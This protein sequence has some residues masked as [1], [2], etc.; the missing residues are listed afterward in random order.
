MPSPQKH[1]P[2]L[3]VEASL[4]KGEQVETMPS[5]ILAVQLQGSCQAAQYCTAAIW[6]Q[7]AIICQQSGLDCH[8][9]VG[10]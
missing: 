2:R 5:C 6:D 8:A 1:A 7:T 4:L 10:W 9:P 3:T